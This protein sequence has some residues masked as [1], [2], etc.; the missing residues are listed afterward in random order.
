MDEDLAE[1]ST[2]ENTI[3]INYDGIDYLHQK[4]SSSNAHLPKKASPQRP[5][6]NVYTLD[7]FSDI[8]DDYVCLK[9]RIC[10]KLSQKTASWTNKF[11]AQDFCE[12]SNDFDCIMNAVSQF[13]SCENLKQENSKQVFERDNI[14]RLQNETD[15]PDSEELNMAGFHGL[16]L[17]KTN[18]GE[19]FVV[20]KTTGSVDFG[21]TLEPKAKLKK[22]SEHNSEIGNNRGNKKIDKE[23]VRAAKAQEKELKKI[24]KENLKELK[25][26]LK[27]IDNSIKPDQ[28]MQY[29]TVNLDDNLQKKPYGET[30]IMLLQSKA[31]NYQISKQC[32]PNLITFTRTVLTVENMILKTNYKQEKHCVT[33]IELPE[34][35]K[36]ISQDSLIGYIHSLQSMP[37]IEHLS[38]A[39]LGLQKYYNTLRNEKNRNRKGT[40]NHKTVKTQFEN[41]PKISKQNIDDHLV[42]LQLFCK[43]LYVRPVEKYEEL[44]IFVGEC[45]KSVAQIPFKAGKE[46]FLQSEN[47]L[48]TVNNRDCV[49]IDKDGNGLNRLWNQFLRMFPLASLETAE[50]ITLVYPTLNSLMEAYENCKE[51]EEGEKLL[52]NISV[53]R[54][55]GPLSGQKKLG[56][57]LS[58]KI[59]K[60]FNSHENVSLKK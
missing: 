37:E 12:N 57:A 3:L 53:R 59:Y 51:P 20:G 26:V 34:L 32:I 28:C 18:R 44:A 23:L 25:R 52:Q 41:L 11:S 49:R 2:S 24:E 6:K 47:Q 1:D 19:S 8:E 5:H 21:D 48:F 39:I 43:K 10:N 7:D 54:A 42:Q 17:Q 9:T 33:V 22:K 4:A 14:K 45:A 27:V 50:A 15:N 55:A 31:Y 56:P 36:L 58:K 46:Q 40:S 30:I 16:E 38:V 35:L 29:F 13:K 60:V